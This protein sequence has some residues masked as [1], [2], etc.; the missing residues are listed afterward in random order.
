MS[1]PPSNLGTPGDAAVAPSRTSSHETYPGTPRWVKV[2]GVVAFVVVLLFLGVHLAGGGMGPSAH[3]SH[4]SHLG[5][6]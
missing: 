5:G 4:L 6:R 1:N 2:F 3:L